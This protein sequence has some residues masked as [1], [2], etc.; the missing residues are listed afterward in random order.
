M[1]CAIHSISFF[2]YLLLKSILMNTYI[3]WT[4]YV[5]LFGCESWFLVLWEKHRPRV[6]EYRFLRVLFRPKREVLAGGWRKLHSEE[7]FIFACII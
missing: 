3:T 4:M 7:L 5:V 6:L 1:G 2:E